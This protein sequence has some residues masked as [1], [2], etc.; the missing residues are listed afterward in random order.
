MTL[1]V[2]GRSSV[3][4]RPRSL[5]PDLETRVAECKEPRSRGRGRRGSWDSGDW[6]KGCPIRTTFKRT[7]QKFSEMD[8]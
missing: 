7:F 2:G 1:L 8:I 3:C 5:E 6:V 4:R